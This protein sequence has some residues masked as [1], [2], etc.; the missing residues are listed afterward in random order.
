MK[1]YLVILG[2]KSELAFLELRTVLERNAK[3]SEKL[4]FDRVEHA[5]II[6]T[7]RELDLQGLI[8][9]L[10]GTVKLGILGRKT[11]TRDFMESLSNVLRNEA[12]GKSKL[13][14]GI[15]MIG[16]PHPNQRFLIPREL[17]E[18][19]SGEGIVSRYVLPSKNDE[20]TS[21]QVALG[22]VTELY[23]VWKDSEIEI[24]KTVAV[25]DFAGF[26]KRDYQRPYVA[27]KGGMLPPKIARQMV[28]LAFST[29]P[30]PNAWILD[31][32]C[33][34]GTIAMEAMVLGINSLSSDHAKDKVDGTKKNLSWLENE[35]GQKAQWKVLKADA[36]KIAQA[37]GQAVDGIVTEPFLGPPN[38]TAKN[39]KNLIK[40]INKLYVGALKNWQKCLRQGGRVV[41][42]IPEIRIGNL[43]ERADL[44]IDR[45]ENLGY[46]LVAGPMDYEREGAQVRR[47]I[48]VLEKEEKV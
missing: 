35:G 47:R 38:P 14:F 7:K 25:Q 18:R 15:S 3:T 6:Q 8:N 46:T 5:A 27:P 23:V 48:Y 24:A 2:R 16:N 42:A 20:L 13:S 22:G 10:G 37:I 45:R 34:T 33:G 40:G 4:D 11:T 44:V 36:T 43:V 28:N 30:S 29:S 21:A 9:I 17:K 19:L 12:I 1:R 39:L 31:P 26:A 32:F 41:M